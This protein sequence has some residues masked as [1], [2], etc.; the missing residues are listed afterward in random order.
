MRFFSSQRERRSFEDR[1]ALEMIFFSN[2]F[3][4]FKGRK[5][6]HVCHSLM[7]QKL[8]YLKQLDI[9]GY[10]FYKQNCLEQKLIRKSFMLMDLIKN[11]NTEHV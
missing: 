6:A 10:L 7:F 4:V 3:V 11:F 9:D 5:H 1:S 2:V 8:T